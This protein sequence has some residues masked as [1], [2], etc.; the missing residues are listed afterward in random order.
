MKTSPSHS[1]IVALLLSCLAMVQLAHANTELWRGVSGTSVSTNWSDVANWN[2]L[3]GTG[4]PGY[5]NNDL[6]FGNVGAE[7]TDNTINSVVDTT[8]SS[9]SMTFTNQ[10][11]NSFFHTVFIPA[12]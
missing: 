10:S 5:T 1:R 9:L 4:N 6:L 12:G 8:S 7:A 3:T 11:Q 2:N